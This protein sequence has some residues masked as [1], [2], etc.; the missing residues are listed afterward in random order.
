MRT[1]NAI[2]AVQLLRDFLVDIDNECDGVRYIS[3]AAG[4]LKGF[5]GFFADSKHYIKRPSVKRP[6]VTL[7][8]DYQIRIWF[9][10]VGGY[11]LTLCFHDDVSICAHTEI[12]D[13]FK[14]TFCANADEVFDLVKSN[15]A[16]KNSVYGFC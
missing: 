8:P 2:L 11:S 16:L 12:N 5:L 1:D 4:S 14:A 7:T 6:S 13:D 15:E 10:Q 9:D 3:I